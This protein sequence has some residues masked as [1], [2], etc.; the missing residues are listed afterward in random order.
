MKVKNYQELIVWQRF[1][2][3]VKEIYE[4]SKTFR[5]EEIMGSQVS[6]GG[7]L[8]RFPLISRKAKAD[9]QPPTF[10]GISRLLT[11]L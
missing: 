7:R 5:R 4:A 8:C 10:Y 6:F 1:M 3:L 11:V 9:E 2:D